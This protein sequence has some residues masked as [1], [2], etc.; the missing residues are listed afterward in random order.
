MI[1]WPAHMQVWIPA[2]L[3]QTRGLSGILENLMHVYLQPE[4]RNLQVHAVLGC[5]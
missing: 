2:S 1:I 5:S 3:T 4:D